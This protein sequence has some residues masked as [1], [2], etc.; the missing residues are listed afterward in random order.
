MKTLF[1]LRHAKSSWSDEGL[2]DF[3]R[4][5]NER[6]KKAAPYMG[7]MIAEIGYSPALIIS[8]TA[9]RARKTAKKFAKAG[10]FK[11]VALDERIYEASA[12]T[13]LY[14]ASETSDDQIGR[15]HV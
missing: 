5:L 9:K 14:I 12:S 8:S 15:A 13:L 7:K 3:D 11:N 4:P 6:G 2:A 1:L 10:N